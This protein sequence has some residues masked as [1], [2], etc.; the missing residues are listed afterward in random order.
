[1]LGDKM[2]IEELREKAREFMGRTCT[3][4]NKEY[5]KN[6][7]EQRKILENKK[8]KLITPEEAKIKIQSLMEELKSSQVVFF[9]EADF[10]E[11]SV[12]MGRGSQVEH[13][14]KHS[15]P[16]KEVGVSSIF[17]WTKLDFGE[18]SPSY[19]PAHAPYGEKH[20]SLTHEEKVIL[21]HKSLKAVDDPSEWD[22]YVINQLE[23]K[24]G[25]DFF[26]RE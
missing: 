19:V 17:I 18:I 26:A 7:K 9:N 13:E 3:L 12:A 6:I 8:N 10:K 14:I 25:K 21:N 24:Y 22:L 11:F 4:T 23:E 2:E 20:D 1:M 16:Y 15:L 5:R